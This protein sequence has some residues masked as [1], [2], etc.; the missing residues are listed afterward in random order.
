M[1]L[2]RVTATWQL[3]LHFLPGD[4]M[5]GIPQQGMQVQSLTQ[6]IHMHRETRLTSLV[7]K[8]VP[9]EPVP[10]SERSPQATVKTHTAPKLT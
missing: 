9:L 4:H 5:A 8:F 1:G 10:L 2:Q 6:E 3:T 7:L